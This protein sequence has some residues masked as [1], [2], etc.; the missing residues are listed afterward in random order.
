M[1]FY[2]GG[3]STCDLKAAIWWPEST[4]VTRNGRVD[5]AHNDID[6]YIIDPSGHEVGASFSQDSVFEKV[7]LP[8]TLNTTGYWR[9]RMHGYSNPGGP[10]LVYYFLYYRTTG[11]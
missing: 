3:G 11:C 6:L 8:S 7:D 4:V 9:F 5:G 2:V 1:A 10:Q